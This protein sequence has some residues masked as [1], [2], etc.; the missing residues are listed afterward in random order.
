MIEHKNRIHYGTHKNMK[1][2]CGEDIAIYF[3]MKTYCNG[4]TVSQKSER[5]KS[6]FFYKLDKYF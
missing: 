6:L 2:I 1:N 4:I 3:H 5:S